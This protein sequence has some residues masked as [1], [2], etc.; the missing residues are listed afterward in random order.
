MWAGAILLIGWMPL[1]VAA[2]G[3]A[4][5][6]SP[7]GDYAIIQEAVDAAD[8]GDEIRIASGTYKENV[9]I[10]YSWLGN[11]QAGDG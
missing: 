5:C 1:P 4:I 2:Q 10:L 7:T 8:D 6:V 9:A 11:G 3:N